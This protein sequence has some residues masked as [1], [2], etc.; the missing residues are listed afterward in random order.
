MIVF[1]TTGLPLVVVSVTV[2]LLLDD[3]VFPAAVKVTVALPEP[4]T[5]LA[6]NHDAS[7]E[8][9]HEVFDVTDTKLDSE[10]ADHPGFHVEVDVVNV[11]ATPA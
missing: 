1:V 8:A 7:D 3:P 9:F 6:V 5:G 4:D 2:P 11:G 10:A